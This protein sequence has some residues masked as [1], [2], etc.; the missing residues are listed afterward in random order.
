MLYANCNA[1]LAACGPW[2]HLAKGNQVGVASLVEPFPADDIFLV[3]VSQ[4][5]DRSAERGNAESAC[6]SQNFQ[7][8]P[9]RF[10][11]RETP[12]CNVVK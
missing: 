2:D 9:E 11:F 1:E 3:K 7:G 5:G 4:M 10:L 6:S 8:I 12:W